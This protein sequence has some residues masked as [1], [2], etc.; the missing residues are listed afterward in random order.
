[1]AV[2]FSYLIF[3][4]CVHV[5]VHIFHAS[6]HVCMWQLIFEADTGIVSKIQY[7]CIMTLTH[8]EALLDF[9][10]KLQISC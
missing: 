3:V 5:P 4:L 9:R 10:T 6:L 8:R 7:S 2:S 1:M